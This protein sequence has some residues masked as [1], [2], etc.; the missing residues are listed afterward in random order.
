MNQYSQGYGPTKKVLVALPKGLLELVDQ[1]AK[2]E[3]RT[4]S[5]LIREALRRY[6]ENFKRNNSYLRIVSEPEPGEMPESPA[7]PGR[8]TADSFADPRSDI[9]SKSEYE[10]HQARQNFLSYTSNPVGAQG[11]S[12][13][14]G[15][16]RSPE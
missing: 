7:E 2:A 11:I 10:Y 16:Y 1:T 12:G 5:D 4:R 8:S 13:N 6:L 3:H 15:D 14:W 9:R